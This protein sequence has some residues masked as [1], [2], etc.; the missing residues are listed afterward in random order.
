MAEPDTADSGAGRAT[1]GP[2]RCD[3][4]GQ[5]VPNVR[6]VALDRGYDRLQK[7][8]AVRYACPSCS[9]KKDRERRERG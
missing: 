4:C 5:E 3:F 2:F 6:R 7:P 9:E 8:H 1:K